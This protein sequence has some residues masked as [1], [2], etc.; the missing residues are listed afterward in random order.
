MTGP[1]AG[2]VV[3]AVEAVRARLTPLPDDGVVRGPDWIIGELDTVSALAGRMVRVLWDAQVAR[4]TAERASV[5]AAARALLNA[6]GSTVG[7]RAAEAALN[8]DAVAAK[9]AADVAD[10]AYQYARAVSRL[11]EDRRSAVQTMARQV[12]ITYSLAGTGRGR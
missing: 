10:A 1:D 8:P 9:E 5:R 11:V 4:D 12:E 6:P 3:D 7:E 2:T